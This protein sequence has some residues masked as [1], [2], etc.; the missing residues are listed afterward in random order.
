MP[1]SAMIRARVAPSLKAEA[2]SVFAQLGLRASD[3]ISLFYA[4]VVLRRSIPFDVSVPPAREVPAETWR[5]ADVL[6]RIDEADQW[7]E[8]AGRLYAA[9]LDE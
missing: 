1:K 5:L 8:F 7:R 4:Q 3:A 9:K 6:D 2:E